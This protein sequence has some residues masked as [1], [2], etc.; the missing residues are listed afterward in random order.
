MEVVDGWVTLSLKLIPEVAHLD[1]ASGYRTHVRKWLDGM[2]LSAGTL[3]PFGWNSHRWL[4][5]Y[6]LAD[7]TFILEGDFCRELSTMVAETQDRLAG[8]ERSGLD[9]TGGD[10]VTA[11]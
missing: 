7:T 5:I 4:D 3:S 8:R 2:S 6:R 11:V 9:G 10:V 1:G